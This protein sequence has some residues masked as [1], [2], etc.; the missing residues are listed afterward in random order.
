MNRKLKWIL[1]GFAIFVMLIQFFPVDRSNPPVE[2]EI[3]APENVKTILRQSCYD[4]HSNETEWPWYSRI[5]PVSWLV[6]HDVNEGRQHLN[7]STWNVLDP[8]DQ[9][10]AI[11]EVWEEIE[12]GEMP[13]WYYLPL[14]PETKLTEQDLS[15]IKEWNLSLES[16]L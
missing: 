4:C 10:K 3:T 16:E 1:L 13:L 8:R 6:A 2:Q 15:L 7:F 11:E 5:A 12:K 9:T 14:H